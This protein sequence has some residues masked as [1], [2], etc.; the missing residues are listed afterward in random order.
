MPTFSVLHEDSLTFGPAQ[1]AGPPFCA[2][3]G[4]NPGPSASRAD[5]MPLDHRPVQHMGTRRTRYV[6]TK[7]HRR[8]RLAALATAFSM[9]PRRH[10]NVTRGTVARWCAFVPR[11]VC[12][13]A[14]N[15]LGTTGVS[16]QCGSQSVLRIIASYHESR[17]LMFAEAAVLQC[18]VGPKPP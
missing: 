8:R 10:V 2:H 9:R 14:C 5:V 12:T 17:P 7:N 18:I 13:V 1:R 6:V 15:H 3:W 11:R 4:L 16:W